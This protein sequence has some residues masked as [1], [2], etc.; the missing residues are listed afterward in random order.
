[1]PFMTDRL[2]AVQREEHLKSALADENTR[3]ISH[4]GDKK[5]ASFLNSRFSFYMDAI[6]RELSS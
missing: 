1:M 6:E 4:K 3:D 2:H 5:R